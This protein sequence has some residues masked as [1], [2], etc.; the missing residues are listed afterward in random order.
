MRT[1]TKKTTVST[2]L[3]ALLRTPIVGVAPA[4]NVVTVVI[5]KPITED[6]TPVLFTVQ[7][8]TLILRATHPTSV[9]IVNQTAV[10]VPYVLIIVPRVALTLATAPWT[11]LIEA[12]RSPIGRSALLEQLTQRL[13]GRRQLG[14]D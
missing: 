8:Q 12:L 4:V 9:E 2:R 14:E 3:S 11:H 7:P 1:R 5:E 6:E 13:L 10:P